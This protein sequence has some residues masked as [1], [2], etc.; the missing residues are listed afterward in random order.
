M[1]FWNSCFFSDPV[2][3][4]NLISGPSA[5][6]KTS[7][8]IWKFKVHVVLKPVIYLGPN[9]GR[10]NEVPCMHYY[11]QCPQPCSRPPQTHASARDSFTLMGKSGSVCCGVT[12]P[13]SWVLVCTGSVCALQDS[14]S[15]LLCKFWQLYGGVSGDLLQEGLCHNPV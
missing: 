14:V 4:G 3:V 1:F 11:T 5:F 6:S 9:C 7:L 12:A 13:F 8:N 10:S 2:D 15:P